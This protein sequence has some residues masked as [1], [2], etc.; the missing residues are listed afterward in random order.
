MFLW[1][2]RKLWLVQP[3]LAAVILAMPCVTGSFI[4]CIEKDGHLAVKRAPCGGS[5]E[6]RSSATFVLAAG[7]SMRAS[8]NDGCGPCIDLTISFCGTNDHDPIV[9][10]SNPDRELHVDTC[11]KKVFSIPVSSQV[12]RHQPQVTT[13]ANPALSCL[14]TVILLI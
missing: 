10:K 14:R 13:E 12:T 2:L 6:Q 7:T 9:R 1:S 4:I 11:S 8:G 5:F 3:Y